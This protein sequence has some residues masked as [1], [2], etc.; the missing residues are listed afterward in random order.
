MKND[1]GLTE[2]DRKYLESVMRKFPEIEQAIIFG[3]RAMGN[4]KRGSDVDLAIIGKN[5]AS[6]TALRLRT[7]L[8]EELPL[9]YFFDVVRYEIIT[10]DNLKQHIDEHGVVLFSTQEAMSA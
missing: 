7:L 5:I 4:S 1:F 9:P 3:S 8:N 2:R 6:A 10:N